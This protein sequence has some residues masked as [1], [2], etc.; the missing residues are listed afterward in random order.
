MG[1]SSDDLSGAITAAGEVSGLFTEPNPF[2]MCGLR[3]GGE[4]E[5]WG[6]VASEFDRPKRVFASVSGGPFNGCGL[7]PWG[8]VECWGF[9]LGD[10]DPLGEFLSVSAWTYHGCGLRAGGSVEC[11]GD[12]PELAEGV[13]PLRPNVGLPGGRFAAV[14]VGGAHACGR[15]PGGEV[16]CWGA[17]WFGQA[18][19]PGGPFAQVDAGAS[20]TCGLRSDGT[21]VCWGQDSL[22][23][24][25]L[26][27][28]GFE[29][30]GDED[31]YRADLSEALGPG[32][33]LS[34]I[35]FWDLEDA[36]PEAEVRREM[37]RRAEGW[38]P[39]AGPFVAISAGHG[40]SCG[41]R[42]DGEAECWGY[43]A[44]EEPRIPLDVYAEVYG[45]RLWDFHDTTK[46]QVAAGDHH[47]YD[48]RFRSLYEALYGTRVWELDPQD[49][50]MFGTDAI[51]L[52]ALVHPL[53]LVDEPPGPF[54]AL[55]AGMGAACGL[56]P[57]GEIDCWGHGPD[58]SEP[59]TG[60]FAT[61]PLAGK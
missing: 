7:R 38:A 43:Y 37:A 42:V 6:W 20:H 54:I 36:V 21:A 23:A 8:Q 31:A 30:G 15:R 50:S 61:E 48:P 35:A 58:H 27:F 25:S 19:A 57:T 51:P 29:F 9:P 44:R 28:G 34:M 22:D 45:P 49:Q 14:S 13:L 39:P 60:P 40:F 3:H 52:D 16:S 4:V 59:P 18:D 11:W 53:R 26:Q 32:I 55:Q 56:R 17:N 33:I 47:S 12:F 10:H 24:A 46:E 5:C 41:L 1:R 2:K